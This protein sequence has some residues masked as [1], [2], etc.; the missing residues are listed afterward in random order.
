MRVALALSCFVCGI[1]TSC[2]P[3]TPRSPEAYQKAATE[4]FIDCLKSKVAQIDDFKSDALAIAV[5][6]QALCQRQKHDVEVAF[7]GGLSYLAAQ[8]FIAKM[9]KMSLSATTEMVL[10]QR[11]AR[12]APK[13]GVTH[14]PAA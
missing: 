7:A 1:M 2:T 4:A 5:A 14:V 6:A 8:R 10:E 12:K 3:S 9:E 11:K 13:I